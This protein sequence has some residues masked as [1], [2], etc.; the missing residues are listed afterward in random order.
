MRNNRPVGMKRLAVVLGASALLVTFAT[1]GQ[2]ASKTHLTLGS[3]NM[4]SSHFV[5]SNAMAKAINQGM[6]GTT[7][8][9]VE[10]GASVDNIRRLSKDELD[11]GL[12]ATDA[13]LQALTGTGAF[14]GKPVDDL[15]ALYSYDVSVLNF[16]VT[17][18]SGVTTLQGLQGRKFNPGIHGSGAELLTRQVFSTLGIKPDLVPG[19]VKD[20]AEAIQNR[21][22]TGYSKYGPGHGVDAT[23]RELLVTT[24][25]RLLG[26]TPQEQEKIRGVAKGVGFT[27][28]QNVMDGA[29]AVETPSV[30]IVFATRTSLMDDQTAYD[31][32][33][34]IYEH[35]NLLIQA[36]PHLKDFDFKKQALAAEEVGIKLHPGAKRFWMS[37][38]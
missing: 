23:L 17:Q 35:R 1:V 21:Q 25:M 3:T 31:I 9:H 24:P 12:V 18:A 5:V 26:F 16:A 33:K 38:K 29:P 10:T 28:L 20:A 22:I 2:A 15:V 19:T 4:T 34:S 13:A 27:K 6:P 32:A 8:T 30:L 37:V 14:K 36:W 7:V 11:L